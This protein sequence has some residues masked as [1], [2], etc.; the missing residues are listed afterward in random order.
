V[1]F[2]SARCFA[3]KRSVSISSGAPEKSTATSPKDPGPTSEERAALIRGL[4]A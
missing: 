3:K 2:L 4:Q 1:I